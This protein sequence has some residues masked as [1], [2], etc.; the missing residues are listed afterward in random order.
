MLT[1][2]VGCWSPFVGCTAQCCCFYI[3]KYKN[4][5]KVEQVQHN[6]RDACARAERI[7]SFSSFGIQGGANNVLMNLL[8][9]LK[10]SKIL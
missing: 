2:F 1:T 8:E 4:A 7:H 5:T 3:Y 6:V 10:G 9:F